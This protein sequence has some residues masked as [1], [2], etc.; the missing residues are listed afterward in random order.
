MRSSEFN[1]VL[2]ALGLMSVKQLQRV[3]R[4]ADQRA[5]AAEAQAAIEEHA[6]DAPTC[7][8]CEHDQVIRWGASES[9]LQRWR[10]RACR[11]TFNSAHGTG[12]ARTKRRDTML[13]FIRNMLSPTPLSCRE[14]AREFGI[15]KMTAWRWRMKVCAA[16]E[17]IGGA[18]F[19]GVVEADETFM[20]ESRKGSREW[21][22]H[23]EDPDVHPR[24]PRMRW[25][26]YKQSDRPMK[27]GLS[28]WQVPI[29][30]IMDRGGQRRAEIL[31]GLA[32]KHIGPVLQNHVAPDAVLCSDKA[33]GYKKF[34]AANNVR[35]VAVAARKGM[36][37][38]DHTFHIQNVNALHS[39]F[40]DFVRPFDGPAKKFLD[41]Y[42][43]WFIFRDMHRRS[44][45][46]P[47][48][49]LKYVLQG[50]PN[51]PAL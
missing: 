44:R 31:T 6:G 35:H 45:G 10:C 16:I 22:R 41:R 1:R 5:R 21:V 42:V 49:L 38:R 26:E 29:M 23:E 19:S 37:V 7:A 50:H 15:D 3:A 14:A 27:R 30:T 2:Q 9:G 18:R 12:L 43:A 25:Y 47:G 34:A 46:A 24:P 36:R 48:V 8:Y 32:F 13:A 17:E 11:R 28:R 33:Q 40:K 51:Q 20:R 4:D 39:R